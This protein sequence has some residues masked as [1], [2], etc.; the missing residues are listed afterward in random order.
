M[1][2]LILFP[3]IKRKVQQSLNGYVQSSRILEDI[4]TYIVPPGLGTQSGV[5]G[6]LALA[7]STKPGI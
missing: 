3:G 6:A 5:F 2:R 4:H 7:Q 1:Q